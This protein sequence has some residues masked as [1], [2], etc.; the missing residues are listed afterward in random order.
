MIVEV[1]AIGQQ[2][3]GIRVVTFLWNR[4][5]QK[6]FLR[7]SVYTGFEDEARKMKKHWGQLSRKFLKESRQ[8]LARTRCFIRLQRAEYP[9]DFAIWTEK[10]R[11]VGVA[12]VFG[13]LFG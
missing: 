7:S 1:R 12:E 5:N 9:A 13:E 10:R 11:K 8:Y 3:G 2:L 6:V 4:M